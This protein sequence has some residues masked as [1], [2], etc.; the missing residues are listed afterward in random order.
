MF[1]RD[2]SCTISARFAKAESLWFLGRVPV[3]CEAEYYRSLMQGQR[4]ISTGSWLAAG[5]V[6]LG[7]IGA[8]AGLK[9]RRFEPE[10]P[11]PGAVTQPAATLPLGSG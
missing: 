10:R 11:R 4:K 2:A 3:R 5:V 7:L 8:L 9:W 1:G 6:A